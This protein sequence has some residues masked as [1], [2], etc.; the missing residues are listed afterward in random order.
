LHCLWNHGGVTPVETV[1]KAV[2]GPLHKKRHINTM[3]VHMTD[4]RKRL[5]PINV[6]VVNVFG[7]GYRLEIF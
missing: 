5:E 7:R 4:L 1:A 2:Y 3:R 6:D